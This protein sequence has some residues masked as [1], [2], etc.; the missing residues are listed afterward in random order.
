MSR[1]D[2]L[3][4]ARKL[5]ITYPDK[6]RLPPLFG[7]PFNVKDSIDIAGLE[8]TTACLPLAYVASKSAK[9]Y[10]LVVDQGTLDCYAFSD[11]P[12]LL[13]K[14]VLS[15]HQLLTMILF[16]SHLF[17]LL[18]TYLLGALLFGKVN[19][20]QLA[21]GLNGC[22][23]PFGI[24]HSVYSDK[25]ISGGSSSGSC[26]SVGADLVTFSLATD[27]A[28]SGKRLVFSLTC[29]TMLTL[30]PITTQKHAYETKCRQGTSRL[31]RS[32]RIQTD[33][34]SNIVRRC[35]PCVPVPRLRCSDGKECRGRPYD[36]ANL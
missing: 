18:L 1:D 4:A 31:Q 3:R 36:M 11:M 35:C 26:V 24:T 15:H 14:N 13:I 29:V 33:T 23:S 19:L 30:V 21:T 6:T 12:T 34:R 10:E 16:L 17:R 28:G 7:V 2:V 5:V 25:H 27:T 20:D 9:C 8:T 22:R 32:C